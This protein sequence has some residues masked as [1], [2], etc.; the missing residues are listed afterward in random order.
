MPG[1][2]QRD[3]EPGADR[4]FDGDYSIRVSTIYTNPAK[5]V[6]RLTLETIAHE[7]ASGEQKQTIDLSPDKSNKPVVVHLSSGRRKK[8]SYPLFECLSRQPLW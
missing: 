1:T 7:G 4:G 6:T 3:A 5:P 2:D 8:V